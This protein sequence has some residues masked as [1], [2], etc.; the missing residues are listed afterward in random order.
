MSL[1]THKSMKSLLKSQSRSTLGLRKHRHTPSLDKSE[2]YWRDHYTWF[3]EQGYKLPARYNPDWTASAAFT[4]PTTSDTVSISSR[5]ADWEESAIV[6][7][8]SMTV[9]ALQVPTGRK[10]LLKRVLHDASPDEVPILTYFS[11][12]PLNTDT[13]NHCIP[14][15]GVLRPPSTR[16][17]ADPEKTLTSSDHLD[18]LDVVA[19]LPTTTA[20]ND[21]EFDTIGEAVDFIRQILRGFRFLHHH[22]VAHRDIRIENLVLETNSVGS[23]SHKH[24]HKHSNSANAPPPNPPNSASIKSPTNVYSTN[25]NGAISHRKLRKPAASQGSPERSRLK[26][27]KRPT[28]TERRPRYMITGFSSS[29]HF[30]LEHGN[31]DEKTKPPHAVLAP[32]ST[33]P[34]LPELADPTRLYDPFPIDVF[35]LGNLLRM[36]FIDVRLLFS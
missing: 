4:A 32:T 25:P 30:G 10:V 23:Y 11:R 15:L 27:E 22:R 34:T 28:R 3:L 24:K 26:L 18:E 20:F 33:D 21:P 5:L 7:S 35:C 1:R 16:T 17:P 13:R 29:V 6:N 12:I 9:P 36:E 14:I 8:A 2:V 31:E 19:V